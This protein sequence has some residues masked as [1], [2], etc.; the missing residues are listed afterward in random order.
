MTPLDVHFLA[1]YANFGDVKHHTTLMK[2][3][4]YGLGIVS[5]MEFLARKG[6]RDYV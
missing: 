5:G 6:V 2:I 4:E 3:L 1:E